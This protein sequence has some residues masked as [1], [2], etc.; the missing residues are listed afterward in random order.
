MIILWF[1]PLLV[2]LVITPRNPC[3]PSSHDLGRDGFILRRVRQ[4]FILRWNTSPWL[5]PFHLKHI[6]WNLFFYL[7]TRPPIDFFQ[8][9]THLSTKNIE[10]GC[11]LIIDKTAKT[12]SLKHSQL[13]T[14]VIDKRAAFFTSILIDV[15]FA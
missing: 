5:V 14:F 11:M 6:V 3:E 12:S 15:L 10:K 4:L 13:S 7:V 9:R 1:E 2:H 8:Q